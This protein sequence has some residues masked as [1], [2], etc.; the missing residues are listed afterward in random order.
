MKIRYFTI[1][2]I[3]AFGSV[4]A[5][6][7]HESRFRLE[8]FHYYKELSGFSP[9]VKERYGRVALDEDINRYSGQNDLRVAWNGNALPHFT[10]PILQDPKRNVRM[11][12]K[13]LFSEEK[14]ESSTYVLELPEPPKGAY[15]TRLEMD[16]Q[17]EFQTSIDVEQGDD[18]DHF[19]STGSRNVYR[20]SAERKNNEISVTKRFVRISTHIPGTFFFPAVYASF[21]KIFEYSLP[22]APEE[23]RTTTDSDIQASVYYYNNTFR[24]KIKKLIFKFKETAFDREIKIYSMDP[25]TKSFREEVSATLKRSANTGAENTIEFQSTA[26]ESLKI[27]IMNGDDAPL[28]LL[29][30]EAKIPAE[31]MIF[32]LPENAADGGNLRLYY[33]N[34][35]AFTP[36]YDIQTTFEEG[37]SVLPLTAGPH[38]ANDQFAYSI[39]EP[40]LSIWIIRAIFFLGLAGMAYPA[41]RI[42]MK[43]SKDM[44]ERRA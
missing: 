33:G 40:P 34:I 5:D 28:T 37:S 30:L 16:S 2:G 41:Y 31:E 8:S 13:V 9:T 10:R 14:E 11:Q 32:L 26:A 27:E 44:S 25:D 43:Y 20:Y 29:S 22:I 7:A 1:P 18:P 24:R 6:T 38:T 4:F 39:I 15:F 42:F 35:Y 36:A 19:F 12:P 17:R 21:E 23:L 3:L